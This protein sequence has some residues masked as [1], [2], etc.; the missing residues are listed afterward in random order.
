[1]VLL[2]TCPC[3]FMITTVLVLLQTTKCSWFFGSKYMLFTLISPAPSDLNVFKHSVDF[4][5]Q[6]FTVPSDEAL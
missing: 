2:L 1:M 4:I 5:L 3:M 6:T